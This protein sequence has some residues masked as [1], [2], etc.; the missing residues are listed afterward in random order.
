MRNKI[1]EFF[2]GFMAGFLTLALFDGLGML[3]KFLKYGILDTHTLCNVTRLCDVD[4]QW[5]GFYM[6]FI[7]FVNMPVWKWS[8]WG[9]AL[10]IVLGVLIG[11]REESY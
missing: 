7:H 6:L 5:L 1:A 8:L 2:G 11:K 9:A 10:C 3:Y 4:I